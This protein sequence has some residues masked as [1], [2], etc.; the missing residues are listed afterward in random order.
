M[1]GSND[2]PELLGVDVQ[3][4]PGCLMLVAH[5]RLSR[6]QVA[7]AREASTGQYTADGGSRDTY[8]AGNARLQHSTAA[9]LNDEQCL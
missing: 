7:E 3:H 6:L 8:I 9:Q 2:T 1:T 5:H 4:V